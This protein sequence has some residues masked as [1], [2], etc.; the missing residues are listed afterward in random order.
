MSENKWTE[1]KKN[2][3]AVRFSFPCQGNYCYLRHF[4]NIGCVKP[5]GEHGHI[6]LQT[7]NDGYLFIPFLCYSQDGVRAAV[8]I[9][10]LEE[11]G[12]T[13]ILDLPEVKALPAE[14]TELEKLTVP[15]PIEKE[16]LNK[17]REILERYRR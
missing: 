6:E 11:A 2:V 12:F 13:G 3:A 16:I 9:L 8:E 1:V 17:L 7:L 5:D 10:K 15:S 4:G 14:L